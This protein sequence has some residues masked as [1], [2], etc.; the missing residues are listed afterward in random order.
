MFYF[1]IYNDLKNAIEL[2]NNKYSLNLQPKISYSDFENYDYQSSILFQI[3]NHPQKNLIIDDLINSLSLTGHYH[4]INITGKGFLS[5]SINYDT[6]LD[7]DGHTK[8]EVVL[9]DYCGVNVAK[10]MHIGHI[11]SMFIGD[12]ISNHHEHL[13]NTVVR[14]NHL[15]DWGNQFGYLLNYIEINQIQIE[16][17]S[18]LTTAYKNAYKK[19]CE[20]PDFAIKSNEIATLL[21]SHC[22]PYYSLWKKCCDISI[23]EM[24]SIT[25]EF[26]LKINEKDIK[27]ES[28]YAPN[29]PF[30]EQ[31]LKNSGVVE[32]GEDGS[33]IYK[34]NKNYP[35]MLKKSNGAY[36]YAMY[37]IAAIYYRIK[38]YDPDQIIYVVDKRQSDHFKAVFELC[39]KMNWSNHVKFKHVAFGF[40]V[41][42]KGTPL[43]TKSGENLYL[44]ELLEI[45]Y[46]E[47]SKQD[48]YN[49]LPSGYKEIVMKNTLY[50]SLKWYD[51]RSNYS[52][53]YQFKW[54]NILMNSAGTAPYIFHAYARINSL[55]F[56]NKE[57][58]LFINED[59]NVS[60]LPQE[61]I[62]L[63]K[64]SQILN[65]QIFLFINDNAAHSLEEK[66]LDVVK[67][68]H[69]FY[70]K[71]N[72]SSSK[73]KSNLISLLFFVQTTIE[74]TCNILGLKTYTSQIVWENSL[75]N[76][77]SYAFNV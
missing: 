26:G 46:K 25:S 21:Q 19:Y 9:V 27:G 6:C 49:K 76:I 4:N 62:D 17:N 39:T 5:F 47:L 44:D 75:N 2:I 36:L 33:I 20:D 13:G 71:I 7:I 58:S 40:I 31:L 3:S 34:T 50:G 43:K 55:L 63:Y 68:F 16:N 38:T 57:N 35:L 77:N 12:F 11:R 18:E 73:Q 61:G 66:L 69:F 28:F 14:I 10:K 23:T 45:G 64:K 29:L 56:K 24:N 53:D 41:D 8:E 65:E 70:E 72:I 32:V 51:L 48:F 59:F 67:S 22:E 15:G 74:D 52:S 60:S 37:D 54:E 30:I 42:D 1:T